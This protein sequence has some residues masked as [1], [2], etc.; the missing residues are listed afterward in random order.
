VELNLKIVGETCKQHAVSKKACHIRGYITNAQSNELKLIV[1]R[2]YLEII[3]NV[4]INCW[5]SCLDELAIDH[6]DLKHW[7]NGTLSHSKGRHTSV[8]AAFTPRKTVEGTKV[9]KP[10][11]QSADSGTIA[12]T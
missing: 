6:C 4:G 11:M 3:Y 8:V 2:E 1:G 9:S 7:H 10:F 12:F 5:Q